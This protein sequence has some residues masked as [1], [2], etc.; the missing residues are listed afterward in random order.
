VDELGRTYYWNVDSNEVAWTRPVEV[1]AI[2]DIAAGY[3]S[4]VKFQAK[5]A[6]SAARGSNS[7]RDADKEIEALRRDSSIASLT[8]Q[9]S[10][11]SSSSDTSVVSVD[12]KAELDGTRKSSLSVDAMKKYAEAKKQMEEPTSPQG[13][14]SQR[15]RPPPKVDLYK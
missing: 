11:C 10:G 4:N 8:K 15:G 5:P 3:V 2:S 6:A 1:K 12:A 9:F 7:S 13:A 14:S